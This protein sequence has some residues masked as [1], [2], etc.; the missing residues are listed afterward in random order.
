MYAIILEAV[1]TDIVWLCVVRKCVHMATT[2]SNK[3]AIS[4]TIIDHSIYYHIA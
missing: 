1:R 3:Q 2:D 4:T